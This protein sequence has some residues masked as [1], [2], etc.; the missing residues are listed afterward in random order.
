MGRSTDRE[1]EP[2]DTLLWTIY[3]ATRSAALRRELMLHYLPYAKK[4]AARLYGKHP[5]SETGVD[6]YMQWASLGMLEAL[7][8]F[9]LDRGAR[10]TTYALPRIIGAIRDGLE[11]LTGQ[12]HEF[13]VAPEDM[14]R[15][16]SDEASP[17]A[18]ADSL[19]EARQLRNRLLSLLE[20]LT[21]R[22]QSVIRLHYL[23]DWTFKDV[24]QALGISK[25]RVSQLHDQALERLKQLL[26][27]VPPHERFF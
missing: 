10:F 26:S 1:P 18:Q 23:Q 4:I 20:Y 22:E 11:S 15:L 24:A 8:H 13:P 5:R 25:G 19:M 6:E 17:H 27:R 21:P 16:L 14:E 3:Q 7:D 12:W 9:R 2:A